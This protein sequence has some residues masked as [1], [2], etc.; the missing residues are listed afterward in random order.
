MAEATLPHPDF[1]ELEAYR[2]GEADAATGAHVDGCEICQQHLSELA[3]LVT[4]VRHGTLQ[5]AL[6]PGETHLPGEEELFIP[7]EV[8][9]RIRW[10]AQQHAARV[11]RQL[12]R[13]NLQR[14]AIAASV[15]L[16]V[17]AALLWRGRNPVDTPVTLDIVDALLLARQLEAARSGDGRYD[18]NHDG[19][20]DAGDVDGILL[21]TVAVGDVS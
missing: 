12:R 1:G 2:R 21:G 18:V 3:Q 14:W 4:L 11:R 16:V 8:D 20:V 15:L 19:R 7:E 6:L 13:Q 5:G 17:G 9:R 10:S